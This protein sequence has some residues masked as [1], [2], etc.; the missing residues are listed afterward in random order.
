MQPTT[1]STS[2]INSI[3]IL[4]GLIMI[5]MALDHVRDFYSNV[6]FDPLDLTKTTIPLF[7][8][9]WI[10]HYCAPIFVFLSGTSAFLSFS[11]G[12][13]KKQVA[14][15]LLTRGLWLIFI[16]VAVVDLLWSFDITYHMQAVQV[17]WAIGWSMVVLA[18]L[19]FLNPTTIAAIGL[20]MIFGHNLLDGISAESFG[21]FKWLWLILHEQGFYPYGNGR[22]L[23]VM[24]PLI[25]WVGVMAT[26]FAFG[27]VFKKDAAYRKSF[28]L[29]V[30]FSAIA[31]FILI[32]F[33]NVYGN[34]TVWQEQD[35]WYKTILSFI[36]CTKYPPSLLY[37]LM[38]LGP[39]ILLLAFFEK[40][41]NR[42][43]NIISVYGKVPFFY[44]IMHLLFIHGSSLLIA[45]LMHIDQGSFGN[46]NTAWGFGL[47]IVY[48][49][50]ICIVIALYFPCNWFMKVKQR[51]KD[52]WLSYL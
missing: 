30:G 1:A 50:W 25:P 49:A 31:L 45:K 33:A 11:K 32:R 6:Q 35:V 41:N 12:K 40:Y 44:Y 39:G 48:L 10:T 37:L 22:G 19:V 13:T 2:R 27:F 28:L 18:G 36:D 29:K 24:Y 7:F 52:W 47:S 15:F 5:I 26:G 46:A 38:T 8:T 20:T 21:S 4:R 42:L 43:T 23:F 9:R 51:R 16:E 34:K 3:D 17:I 14:Q